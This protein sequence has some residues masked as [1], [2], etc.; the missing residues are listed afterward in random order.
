MMIKLLVRG[1]CSVWAGGHYQNT[2]EV[3]TADIQGRDTNGKI[4]EAV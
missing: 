3:C 4:V 2:G 1:T